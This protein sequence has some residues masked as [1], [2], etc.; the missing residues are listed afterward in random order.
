MVRRTLRRI[1]MKHQK[2]I[3]TIP[4][5]CHSFSVRHPSK[6]KIGDFWDLNPGQKSCLKS[7]R[8]STTSQ[9][10]LSAAIYIIYHAGA[11]CELR[12]L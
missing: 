5:F 7:S 12:R 2:K 8:P 3:V 4:I 11:L 10:P 9:T 6:K 1:S